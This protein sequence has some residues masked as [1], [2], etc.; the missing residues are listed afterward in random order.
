MFEKL[1]QPTATDLAEK[2]PSPEE[3]TGSQALSWAHSAAFMLMLDFSLSMQRASSKPE[4]L[5][6]ASVELLKDQLLLKDKGTKAKEQVK[7]TGLYPVSSSAQPSPFMVARNITQ[8]GL[9]NNLLL[10]RGRLRRL[11]KQQ[12][13]ARES[14]RTEICG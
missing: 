11:C 13:D 6:R 9:S 7:W 14:I 4:D 3:V 2:N 8:A 12:Y 5:S 1:S 10:L